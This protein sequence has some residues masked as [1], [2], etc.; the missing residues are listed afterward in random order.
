[1]FAANDLFKN[2]MKEGVLISIV[3]LRISRLKI[4]KRKYF[5]SPVLHAAVVPAR[6]RTPVR[7]PATAATIDTTLKRIVPQGHNLPVGSGLG[8]PLGHKSGHTVR[9]AIRVRTAKKG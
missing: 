6:Q 9:H 2:I 4:N 8:C 3:L 7:R 1:M 5:I